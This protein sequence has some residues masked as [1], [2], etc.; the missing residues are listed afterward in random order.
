MVAKR[1]EDN[2]YPELKC[3]ACEHIGNDYKIV[4]G[5]HITCYCGNCGA[6]IKNLSKSDKYGTKEQQSEIWAKTNG[7]CCY[8]SIPLNQ[9]DKNGYTY[10]HIEPQTRGG[11]H[12]TENLY[13]CCKSCNSQ[14]GKKTLKEYRKYLADQHNAPYWVFHFEIINYSSLGEIIKK[15][16]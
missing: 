7:H 5:I 13:P 11:G 6:Y 12:N 3:K 4:E 10:E 15:I 1:N 9:F 14:K 16:F 8:C 2:F